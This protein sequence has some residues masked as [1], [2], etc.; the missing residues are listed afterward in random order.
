MSSVSGS[1]VSPARPGRK[2]VGPLKRG[3]LAIALAASATLSSAAT[4]DAGFR[5]NVGDYSLYLSVMPAQVIR[6]PVAPED[7]AAS[8]YRPPA[9]RD[10]HHVMVSIFASRDGR[11]VTD[12]RVAA[13]VAALGFSGEKKPLEST[14][15]AGAVVYGGF[16]PMTGRGPYRVDVEFQT[17]PT[18]LRQHASFY[19][20]HPNF[21]MPN[22][23]AR[24]G[25]TP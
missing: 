24:T 13:R 4:A 20:T 1:G 8:P 17:P 6:G 21:E 9:A 10:T 12:A 25:A 22:P 5:K 11:R 3:V 23:G 16:F 15:V 19:F 2:S 7:P 18:A 14:A